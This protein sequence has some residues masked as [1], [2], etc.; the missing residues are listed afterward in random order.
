MKTELEQVSLDR[1]T[2]RNSE[3]ILLDKLDV[4]IQEKDTIERKYESC[5]AHLSTMELEND[6][7]KMKIRE[8]T[9][10]SN[11]LE[12][13]CDKMESRIADLQSKLEDRERHFGEQRELSTSI[14]AERNNLKNELDVKTLE[15]IDLNGIWF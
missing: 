10:K 4:L 6:N 7:L 12:A 2:L 5:K 3:S 1:D 14:E 11:H 8:N 13:K 9:S 15:A